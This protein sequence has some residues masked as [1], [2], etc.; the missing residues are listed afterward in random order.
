MTCNKKAFRRQNEKKNLKTQI[1]KL[2]KTCKLFTHL[3]FFF[4]C[5][6]I[7]FCGSFDGIRGIHTL[8]PICPPQ[9]SGLNCCHYKPS[10]TI[11][12]PPRCSF[13]NATCSISFLLLFALKK[14]RKTASTRTRDWAP[15]MAPRTSYFLP[16]AAG[17]CVTARA[18]AI[19]S[20][21]NWLLIEN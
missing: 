5:V 4:V 8:S 16:N 18:C 1:Q 2:D 17:V 6:S 7:V 3:I 21:C 15:R 12:T 13:N 14:Q 9:K 19:A 10:T 20:I 11:I